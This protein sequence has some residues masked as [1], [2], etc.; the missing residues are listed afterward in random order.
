MGRLSSEL[1]SNFSLKPHDSLFRLNQGSDSLKI[2]FSAHGCLRVD[3][4]E[5]VLF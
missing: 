4:A 3:S 1:L 2:G 5:A